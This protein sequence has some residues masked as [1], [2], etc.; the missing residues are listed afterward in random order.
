MYILAFSIACCFSI[1]VKQNSNLF[2]LFPPQIPVS[3][4]LDDLLLEQQLQNELPRWRNKKVDEFPRQN[5]GD[6]QHLPQPQ[7]QQ[8]QNQQIPVENDNNT[9]EPQDTIESFT[10]TKISL[11]LLTIFVFILFLWLAKTKGLT[12]KRRFNYIF[13]RIGGNSIS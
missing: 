9:F 4:N 3:F 7:H 12:I 10:L 2:S 5:F 11:L 13:S 8:Q 1:D 6:S